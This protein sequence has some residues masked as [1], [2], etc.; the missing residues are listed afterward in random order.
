MATITWTRD[1]AS[2]PTNA[3]QYLKGLMRIETILRRK[4]RKEKAEALKEEISREYLV[5]QPQNVEITA[6]LRTFD[7]GMQSEF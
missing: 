6:F 4:D 5:Q 1:R 2:L 3:L 7:L